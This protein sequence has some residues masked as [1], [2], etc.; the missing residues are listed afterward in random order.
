MLYQM[1]NE[2][3]KAQQEGK[4]H[5]DVGPPPG[6]CKWNAFPFVSIAGIEK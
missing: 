4:Q 1:E 5:D 6:F 2:L 3:T